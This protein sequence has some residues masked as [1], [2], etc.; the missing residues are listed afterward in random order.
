MD[1]R[2]PLWDDNFCGEPILQ[3][4]SCYEK[5]PDEVSIKIPMG[6]WIFHDDW[7]YFFEMAIDW[8]SYFEKS[9]NI[10]KDI[11]FV[12]IAVVVILECLDK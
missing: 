5:L 11:L 2:R 8:P 3:C 6:L 1:Y 7:H 9:D 12:L 4:N 10:I